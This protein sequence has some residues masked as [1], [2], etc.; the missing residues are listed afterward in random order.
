[1]DLERATKDEVFKELKLNFCTPLRNEFADFVVAPKNINL[2]N[3]GVEEM[4]KKIDQLYED[5]IDLEFG[6]SDITKYKN[7][8]DEDFLEEAKDIVDGY[9]EEEARILRDDSTYYLDDD[10]LNHTLDQKRE[11]YMEDEKKNIEY[12]KE[13]LEEL[14][15]IEK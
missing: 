10:L 7:F 14:P 5:I 12:K 9:I 3:I 2:N 6:I 8:S 13:R 1:M 11:E 4:D 15:E